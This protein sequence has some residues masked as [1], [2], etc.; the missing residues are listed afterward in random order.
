MTPTTE[1][2]ER[3]RAKGA[4]RDEGVALV[5]AL[6]FIVLLTALVIDFNF[7]TQVDASLVENQVGRLEAY[8]AAKSAIAGG[9]G[10]LAA[11]QYGD[12]EQNLQQNLAIID[13]LEDVWVEGV[14]LTPM[15]E[16]VM[17]CR[18]S[19]EYGKINLN[20]LIEVNAA[21]EEEVRTHVYDTIRFL[22]QFRE[23]EPN[24][25]DAIVD[26][27][28]SDDEE[29]SADGA[30]A[31]YYEG[32][33]TPYTCKNGPMDS[34][35]ELLLIPGITP[36]VY[37]GDPEKEQLPLSELFTVHGHPEGKINVNTAPFEVLE[38]HF[39]ADGEHSPG[40]Q[41][42]MDVLD[43]LE[44]KGPFESVSALAEMNLV[45]SRRA[46]Q[47]D[48]NKQA[49][50]GSQNPPPQTPQQEEGPPPTPMLDVFSNVFRLVADGQ[51]GDHMIRIEAYVFRT[52]S[53]LDSDQLFR[54]INWRI[55]Q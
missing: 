28:D 23:V 44:S 30:E 33:E 35:E 11:D 36:E 32:L 5:L 29:F 9:L 42:A 43:H 18:I 38:A 39:E 3:K 51:S 10:L 4:R 19:D 25:V 13:S 26:W 49:P 20:A 47:A 15:N 45:P 54:I 16:A 31:R 22:F 12:L 46:R 2:T 41:Y 52:P 1:A 27:L 50:R 17:Q 48:R 40:E 14:P 24:P 8:L 53:G 37:Y 55:I 34:V 6:L 7:E 21:G